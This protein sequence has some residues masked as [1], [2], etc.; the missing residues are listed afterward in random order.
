MTP[1]EKQAYLDE[2]LYPALLAE[3]REKVKAKDYA[4]GIAAYRRVLAI[5]SGPEVEAELRRAESEKSAWDQL[6]EEE[7]RRE[8]AFTE[9]MTLARQIV[10][11][12]PDDPQAATDQHRTSLE[13]ARR[14]VESALTYKP[15]DREAQDLK[16]RIE[17]Y[18]GPA[19]ELTLDLGG[20]VKLELVLIPA[21]DF[22]MGSPDSEKDRSLDEGPQHQVRISQPFYIGKTEVTQGQWQA[23][24]G[25]NPSNFKGDDRLPVETV[26]WDDCQAFCQKLNARMEGANARWRVRLPTEAEWEYACRAGTSTPFSFGAT[27]SP[28]QVNYDGNNPYG[29]GKKGEF[30][31]KTMPVGSFPA[32]A[33]G[34]HDMHGNV[35]EWCQDWHGAYA[36]SAQ[37]DPGGP[38]SGT[39]R[40]LRGGCW[41]DRAVGCR[42]AP[43]HWGA[44]VL[45]GDGIGLRVVVD[46]E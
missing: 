19:K 14:A 7:R 20:G 34:L 18:F 4:A 40:V 28:A 32:N 41:Y 22:L 17:R 26:S 16:A 38:N 21:G 44:P 11:A 25:N 45:R 9:Q 2:K 30:R 43:R 33:W 23:V 31:Q 5:R 36:S 15:Q 27:I 1:A 12:V 39:D 37:V 3:A 24:M 46:S 10:A 35:W 42:S 13:P 29:S 6:Q 8:Q